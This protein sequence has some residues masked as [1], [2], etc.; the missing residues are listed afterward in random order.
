MMKHPRLSG[1]RLTTL[2]HVVLWVKNLEVLE[3]DVFHRG[4]NWGH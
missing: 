3:A 4:E 2:L 1:L